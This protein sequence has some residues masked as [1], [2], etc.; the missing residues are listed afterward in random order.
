VLFQPQRAQYPV[1]GGD[2][3]SQS[4]PV[5]REDDPVIH[6]SHVGHFVFGHRPVERQQ[7]EGTHQ[8][9]KGCAQRNATSDISVILT[10]ADAAP[11]VLTHQVHDARV[12]N[13]AIEHLLEALVVD[14]GV[15]A[16]HVTA[17]DEFCPRQHGPD[18]V[19]GTVDAAIPFDV[20]AGRRQVRDQ[21]G[22]QYEK[23]FS[24]RASRAL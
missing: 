6:E 12:V 9:R 5:G 8:R 2:G 13:V 23:A 11:Q 1:H 16:A 24:T 4:A 7:V 22:G 21:N 17:T 19:Q 14:I 10:A 18:S 15:V 20:T 3:A